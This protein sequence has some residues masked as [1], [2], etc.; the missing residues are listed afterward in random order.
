MK[1][2][3]SSETATSGE[4]KRSSGVV[5]SLLVLV[6]V[7]FAGVHWQQRQVVTQVNLAGVT[8]LSVMPVRV[9]MDSCVNQRRGKLDLAEV[10]DKLLQIPFV[11]AVHVYYDGI[12]SV[13]AEVEE[14]NP[15]AHIVLPDGS[16]RYVDE[17]GSILPSA[18]VRTAHDVPLVRRADHGQLTVEQ[19]MM[20]S[21]LLS[22]AMQNLSTTLY[23]AISEVLITSQSIEVITQLGS[24]KLGLPTSR[25]TNSM[26]AA[27]FKN[28]TLFADRT[29]LRCGHC[30]DLDLRWTKHIVVRDR[31]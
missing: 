19:R 8:G 21:R 9:V 7:A 23:E 15:L 22:S 4:R 20:A 5:V 18:T 28:L 30:A 12:R 17:A 25:T 10:R 3:G 1:Q 14:R 29:G 16:I 31:G 26:L 11:K 2:R 24:W 13:K 27:T 6:F